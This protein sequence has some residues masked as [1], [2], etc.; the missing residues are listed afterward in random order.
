MISEISSGVLRSSSR[1]TN[2]I[3]V[4]CTPCGTVKRQ[5]P[6]ESPVCINHLTEYFVDVAELFWGCG[7]DERIIHLFP[8]RMGPMN[9]QD[10]SRIHSGIFLRHYQE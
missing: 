2:P 9:I 3:R 8:E 4:R 7:E 1:A 6:A 10:E 5:A